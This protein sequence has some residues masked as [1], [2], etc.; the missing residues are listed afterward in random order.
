MRVRALVAASICLVALAACGSGSPGTD[1]G[2]PS[3]GIRGVVVAGP[4]CPVVV[5]GSPCPD[6]PWRG[7][8]RAS[9]A[10][11]TVADEVETDA[12]GRF[13]L[14]VEPGTYDVVPVL[15]TARLPSASPV[16]VTVPAS[17]WVDVE[18]RVDTGIR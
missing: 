2:A 5:Q 16:T 6:R 3:G 18:L 4:Q 7:L 13:E 15:E 11:G 1:E 14:V 12:R 10:R 8:V 17:G 9:T